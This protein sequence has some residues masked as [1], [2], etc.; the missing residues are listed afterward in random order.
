MAKGEVA[1]TKTEFLEVSK[2]KEEAN[3]QRVIREEPNDA[4][5]I[6]A[7]ECMFC[8][9]VFQSSVDCD[10]HMRVHGFRICWEGHVR[11]GEGLLEYLRRKVGVRKT[12]LF[13]H[14]KFGSLHG[15]R[16][17]MRSKSHCVYERTDE[18]SEFYECEGERSRF[19]V[20][21]AG[22]L[23]TPSGAI[24]GHRLLSRYYAQRLS[25]LDE[26]RS[27]C[28]VAIEG[29]G[30][31]R[32]SVDIARDGEARVAEWRRHRERGRREKRMSRSGWQGG[33]RADGR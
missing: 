3:D 24:F 23:H 33:G 27:R 18:V 32:E 13:C 30:R 14:R 31:P 25:D 12:C 4:R 9:E 16:Q 20:D 2:G 6:P 15:A 17:H 22:E 5:S 1:L 10:G 11:D 21:A 26:L 28:R 7:T 8:G 19:E 29:P